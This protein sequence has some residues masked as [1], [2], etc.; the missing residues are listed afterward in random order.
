MDETDYW[1]NE[2]PKCP[3]CGTDFDV[4][5]GDRPLDLN[6][7]DGGHTTFNCGSCSKNFVCVTEVH[8]KFSTAVSDEAADDEQWGPQEAD[9]A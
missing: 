1:R 3:H 5:D 7:E 8:Y 4:W 9:A 6:Y 2:K